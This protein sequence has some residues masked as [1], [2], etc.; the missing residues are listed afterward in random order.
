M[1]KIIIAVSALMAYWS[2]SAQYISTTEVGNAKGW[3]A[4]T[5]DPVSKMAGYDNATVKIFNEDFLYTKLSLSLCH[6]PKPS[7][8]WIRLW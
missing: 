1:K 4:Y 6:H 2:A 8:R 5:S 3:T 7:L